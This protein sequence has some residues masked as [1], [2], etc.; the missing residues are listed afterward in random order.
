[1][2]FKV[3]RMPA[4]NRQLRELA[5]RAKAR[6]IHNSFGDALQHMLVRLQT[7]PLE[8]GDPE[9]NAHHPGGLFCHAVVWPLF[10]RF[11]VYPIE[12][13]VI[14]FDITPLPNTHVVDS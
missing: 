10:V 1:M 11:A 6:R 8:W 13:T 5:K 9:Y 3:D 4:V 7:A 12:E 14:I 2:T